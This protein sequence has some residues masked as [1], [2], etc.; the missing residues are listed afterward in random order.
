VYRS[1]NQTPAISVVVITRNEGLILRNTVEN[2]QYTLPPR[3]EILVVDD[4]SSDGSTVF[5]QQSESSA[6][7]VRAKRR[8][9]VA[10]A[11]NFG[12]SCA[13]GRILV[14]C[15]AHLSFPQNWHR[16]MV[17]LLDDPLIGAVAPCISDMAVHHRKGFGLCPSGPDLDVQWLNRKGNDPYPVPLLPGACMAMRRDTFQHTDGF[18]QGLIRY[19]VEDCELSL[20]FWLMGYELWLV[21]AV[22]VAHQF[23][24]QIPYMVP[25]RTVL[26]NR[27]RMAFLHLSD[28]RRER[29]VKT[30]E[31]Y[32]AFQAAIALVSQGDVE[33][34]R[35]DLMSRR[36]RDDDW[37]FQRFRLRW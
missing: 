4:M 9:G 10:Q 19:G 8:L 24:E 33:V 31:T 14:F 30:L 6:R 2:L 36:K 7:L 13:S 32:P 17:E 26:H 15:D 37:Y 3:H 22:D 5:L 16:P 23:R 1:D 12:A 21:P 28:S 34:R 20:R 27:L 35:A 11:R 29:V 18:D 25:W